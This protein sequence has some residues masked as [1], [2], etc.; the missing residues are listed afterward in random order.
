MG[1]GGPSEPTERGSIES[2]DIRIGIK[3]TSR[4]VAF[5]SDQTRDEVEQLVT[6]A[7]EGTVLKLDD[8]KGRR[9]I[10]PAAQIA[11]VEIGD[12]AGRRIGFV[13]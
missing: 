6:A 10:I 9:F 7:L 3:D 5:D 1:G 4:E 11:Y 13:A 8:S 2:M 12:D